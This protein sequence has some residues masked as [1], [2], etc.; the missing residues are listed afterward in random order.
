MLRIA[1]VLFLFF[2]NINLRAD[3]G[4]SLYEEGRCLYE[5]GEMQRELASKEKEKKKVKVLRKTAKMNFHEAELKLKESIVLLEEKKDWGIT[6]K[7][8]LFFMKSLRKQNKNQEI[9]DFSKS[10]F[11]KLEKNNIQSNSTIAEMYVYL[12]LTYRRLGNFLFALKKYETAIDIFEALPLDTPILAFAYKNTALIYSRMLEYDKEKSCLQK[13]LQLK[14]KGKH[15][16]SIHNAFVL[17]YTHLEKYDSAYLYYQKGLEAAQNK[18]NPYL[19]AILK[20]NTADFLLP[21]K[22]N[23][24]ALVATQEALRYF[25]ENEEKHLDNTY[26][27]LGKIYARMG[28]KNKSIHYYNKALEWADKK[29]REKANFHT[30]FGDA[31]KQ[32][33]DTLQALQHYQQALIQVL[34]CFDQTD[35]HYNPSID[36]VY[37]ESWIMTAAA[38]KAEL[39]QQRYEKSGNIEDLKIAA[40]SY[41]LSLK[42]VDLLHKSYSADTSKHYLSDYSRDYYEQ[43][44]Y[45]NFL[46]Y[47]QTQEKKHLHAAFRI[48]EQSKA[49][50][51]KEAIV[52]NE[53]FKKLPESIK[54]QLRNL[55]LEISEAENLGKKEISDSLNLVYKNLKKEVESNPEFA[56]LFNALSL[57]IPTIDFLQQQLPNTHFV[58]Y[59]WGRKHLYQLQFNSTTIQLDTLSH[60]ENSLKTYIKLLQN[61]RGNEKE[62]AQLGYELYQNYC[63]KWLNINQLEEQIISITADGLLN[64]LPFEALLTDT[65]QLKDGTEFMHQYPRYWKYLLYHAPIQYAYSV[66]LLSQQHEQPEKA[67]KEILGFFPN[68]EGDKKL[69]LQELDKVWFE[70]KYSGKFLDEDAT[71][72]RFQDLAPKAAIIH[73]STHAS[74]DSLPHIDF[75]DT[76]FSLPTLYAMQLSADLVVLSACETGLGDLLNGEGVMSL[77][78]GFAYS[79]ASNMMASLWSVREKSTQFLTQEFYKSLEEGKPKATALHLA[80][81]KYLESQDMGDNYLPYYWVGMVYIGQNTPTY[82]KTTNNFLWLG[83]GFVLLL[84]VGFYWRR[85]SA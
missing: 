85:K 69:Q 48:M 62:Y 78:R 57:E 35:I 24:E 17:F 31:Y 72:T 54:R 40:E 50:A 37:Q 55:E 30:S 56:K 25:S 9:I 38:R 19:A 12:A 28:E 15:T 1:A 6:T 68:F 4:K 52:K 80:K 66:T 64:Y 49:K 75:A 53:V 74:A 46:L 2:L 29:S 70:G 11:A 22:Q 61:N 59:F 84:V 36:E 44:L 67:T 32:W 7:A 27:S 39:L 82:L 42:A 58:E 47:T 21:L 83:F 18:D 33:N 16:P 79:G 41:D 76:T 14:N 73:L 51:L 20:G 60:S 8:Y 43:A 65:T 3:K 34:P 45:T 26:A 13:A 23:K 63:S 5:T 71:T 10:A 77:A 81:K